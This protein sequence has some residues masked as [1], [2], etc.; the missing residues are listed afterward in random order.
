MPDW[1][2]KAIARLQGWLE[3]NGFDERVFGDCSA[4]VYTKGLVSAVVK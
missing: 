1:S 4:F 3:K 2:S